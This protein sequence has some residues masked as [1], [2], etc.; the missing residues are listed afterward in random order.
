M[1]NSPLEILC[2]LLLTPQSLYIKW[3]MLRLEATPHSSL[4]KQS[5]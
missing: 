3:V 5:K 4:E 2:R 1:F